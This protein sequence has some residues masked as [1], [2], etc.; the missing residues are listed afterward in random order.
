MHPELFFKEL[1]SDYGYAC[2]DVIQIKG[3]ACHSNG[4]DLVAYGLWLL[5][6]WFSVRLSTCR[7]SFFSLLFFRLTCY[8]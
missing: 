5:C 4:A 1:G 7:L 6:Q 8:L 2:P 3:S